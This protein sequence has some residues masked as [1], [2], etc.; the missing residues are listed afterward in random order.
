MGR[1]V[2]VE[3]LSLDGVFEAPSWTQP[4]FDDQVG[5]RQGEVVAWADALLLGRVTYE[6]MSRASPSMGTEPGTG[7]DLMNPIGKDVPTRR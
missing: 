2:V 3:Y 6:Q 5:A 7:G 4:S 1:I